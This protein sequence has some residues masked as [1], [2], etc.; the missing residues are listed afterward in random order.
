MVMVIVLVLVLVLVEAC[1]MIDYCVV[2]WCGAMRF[3]LFVCL[4]LG[5][6][7]QSVYLSTAINQ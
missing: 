3:H 6:Y 5:R 2:W 4:L 7:N 1:S